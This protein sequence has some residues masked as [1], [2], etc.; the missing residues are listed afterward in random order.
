MF[1]QSWLLTICQ[2]RCK[3]PEVSRWSFRIRKPLLAFLSSICLVHRCDAWKMMKRT[4]KPTGLKEA[5]REMERASV[6]SLGALNFLPLVLLCEKNTPWFVQTTVVSFSVTS[7]LKAFLID[8]KRRKRECISNSN[9]VQRVC[10]QAG[11]SLVNWGQSASPNAIGL[12]GF[13]SYW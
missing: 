13:V 6:K 4:W 3:L 1:P 9:S 8:T 12:N 5:G 7:H 11:Q 10:L 2:M